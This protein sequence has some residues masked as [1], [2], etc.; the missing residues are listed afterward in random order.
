MNKGN[1]MYD[2]QSSAEITSLH[3][4]EADT[5]T[6]AELMKVGASLG[7]H[8]EIYADFAEMEAYPP[9]SGLIIVRDQPDTNAISF[10]LDQLMNMGVSLPV[11]AM[12]KDPD[13]GRVVQA[14][15]GGALDYLVLPLRPERLSTCLAR[16]A[17]EAE[18][19]S[20]IRQRTIAAR[21]KIDQLSPRENEVLT[22]LAVGASNKEIARQLDI[23]PRTVE[24]HRANMMVKVGA[25]H[26]AEAI[27]VKME[28]GV[29]PIQL[30][31]Q[32]AA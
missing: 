27:R 6:R 16:I 2:K 30:H 32:L 4:V 20:G 18:Q 3:F 7:L 22:A 19:V 17:R 29:G 9:R 23:S 11:V 24:I 8:C 25:R 13:P 31:M 21:R 14:V 26:T 12:D 15:K 28:A 5:H 1:V 10:A